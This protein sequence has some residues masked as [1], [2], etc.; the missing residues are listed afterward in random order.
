MIVLNGFSAAGKL[1]LI[2][3]ERTDSKLVTDALIELTRRRMGPRA[4]CHLGRIEMA[5]GELKGHAP[6]ALPQ[7]RQRGT[8]GETNAAPAMEAAVIF[9]RSGHLTRGR[10]RSWR[11]RGRGR[12]AED[13]WMVSE[14]VSDSLVPDGGRAGDACSVRFPRD[15]GCAAQRQAPRM[16]KDRMDRL[17]DPALNDLTP[18][19]VALFWRYQV[20]RTLVD[21]GAAGCFLVDWLFLAGS[22]LFALKPT[23]D[24]V[25]SAHLRRLPGQSDG[26]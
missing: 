4:Q 8:D 3:P 10:C 13:H 17:L 6:A 25:R 14:G 7:R 26:P 21:F 20:V 19:H 1:N 2:K 23:I 16:V 12:L 22:V 24:V 9:A 5:R 15:L 18:S 11:R